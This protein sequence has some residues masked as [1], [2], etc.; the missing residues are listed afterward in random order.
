MILIILTLTNFILMENKTFLKRVLLKIE[1][2]FKYLK[3]KLINKKTLLVLLG[4][5]LF[6]RISKLPHYM[7]SS[8]FLKH[9]DESKINDITYSGFLASFTLKDSN[10]QY[11][12]N[13]SSNIDNFNSLLSTK[14]INFNHIGGLESIVTNPY[15]QFFALSS[16]FIYVLGYNFNDSIFHNEVV[17]KEKNGVSLNKALDGLITTQENKD[18]FIL[19]VDQ[20]LNPNKYKIH[21]IRPI[22]GILL[23]GKPGT[24]K[25]LLAK[26]SNS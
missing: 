18:N 24:G 15:N 10:Q 20:L 7:T 21:Q 17:N 9:I 8:E 26:V 1:N 3:N 19:A 2:L 16:V 22:K 14:N 13:Y 23:Y 6:Y 5:L 25:T 12:T 4:M 11:L